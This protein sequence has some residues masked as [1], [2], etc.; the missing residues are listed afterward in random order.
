MVSLASLY[1]NIPVCA[2]GTAI[3]VPE[4]RTYNYLSKAAL[5]AGQIWT[6]SVLGPQV[7]VVLS[8]TQTL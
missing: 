4:T 5:A 8:V 6:S 7:G 1:V 2:G 3:V